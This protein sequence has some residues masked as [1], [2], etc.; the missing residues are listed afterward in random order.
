[1]RQA[2]EDHQYFR[3]DGLHL[4]AAGEKALCVDWFRQMTT[5]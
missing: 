1:V 5:E 3:V 4:N 2:R